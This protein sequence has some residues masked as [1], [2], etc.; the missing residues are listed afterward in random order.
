MNNKGTKKLCT[1]CKA[2]VCFYMF[3]HFK[4]VPHGLPNLGGFYF[5]SP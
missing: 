1:L 4:Q 5:P 2:I 3:T